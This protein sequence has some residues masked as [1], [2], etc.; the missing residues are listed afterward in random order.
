MNP[1]ELCWTTGKYT[2]DCNCDFCDFKS[3]CSG[4]EDHD[5]ED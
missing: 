1:T 5:D 4:F 2:E 3:E